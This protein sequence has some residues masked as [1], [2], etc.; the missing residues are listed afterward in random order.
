MWS[1]KRKCGGTFLIPFDGNER[2][3][4]VNARVVWT[5]NVLCVRGV[6]ADRNHTVDNDGREVGDDGEQK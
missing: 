3:S 1:D 2:R 4:V 6:K 5:D